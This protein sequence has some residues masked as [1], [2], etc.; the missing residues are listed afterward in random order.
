M[1][2]F[3]AFRAED[4]TPIYLQIIKYLKQG[5]VSGAVADGDELPSRR[6]LSALLG[7]NPNTVQKACRMLE[8]EGLLVSHAGAKSCVRVT[9]E[10]RGAWCARSSSART[11]WQRPRPSGAWRVPLEEAIELVEEGL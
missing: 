8:E 1:I 5:V 6:V 10:L 7:L 3:G 2:D 4:G 11:R 9:P